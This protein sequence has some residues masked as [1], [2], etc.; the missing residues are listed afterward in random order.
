MVIIALDSGSDG[1]PGVS[2]SKYALGFLF[3]VLGSA[4]HGLIF[5]LSEVVFVKELGGGSRFF[6][7]VLEF[8]TMVSLI[9]FAATTVG[10]VIRGDFQ[11]M[12]E[13]AGQFKHGEQ[14]YIMVLFW[15]AVTFQLGVQG[16]TAV[17]YLASTVMA[18][19]LNAVRVPLT[20]VAA[21]LLFKDSMTGFKILSLVIT[22]W[23]FVSYTW[24]HPSVGKDS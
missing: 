18:G 20:S 10:V 15:A 8:Q 7:V 24:G 9:A 12:R 21:V 22:G 3:D 5:A 13:E 19:I 1:S 6:H 2:R 16:G 17:V 11:L 23:G 4:I 14:S